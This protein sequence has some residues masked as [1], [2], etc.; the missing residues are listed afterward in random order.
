MAK[1]K[2]EKEDIVKSIS[3]GIRQ[4]ESIRWYVEVYEHEWIGD[5]IASTKVIKRSDPHSWGGA[6]E[7]WKLWAASIIGSDNKV[8]F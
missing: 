2:K 6:F 8:N 7:K 3:V 4:I 5:E 1:A